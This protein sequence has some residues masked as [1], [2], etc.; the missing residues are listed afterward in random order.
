MYYGIITANIDTSPIQCAT[1]INIAG[2]VI[3]LEIFRRSYMSSY[4]LLHLLL[5]IMVLAQYRV[6]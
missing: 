6:R 5:L 1:M 4:V 3:Y 2:I